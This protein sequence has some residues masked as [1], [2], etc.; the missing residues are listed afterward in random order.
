MLERRSRTCLIRDEE[1]IRGRRYI[2]YKTSSVHYSKEQVAETQD[3]R[4]GDKGEAF[5]PDLQA[6][7]QCGLLIKEDLGI[8]L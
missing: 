4:D 1:G 5:T 6:W 7:K 2:P 3:H 8:M